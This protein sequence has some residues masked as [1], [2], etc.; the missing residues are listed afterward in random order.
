[1]STTLHGQ[2]I[3]ANIKYPESGF[4]LV[5]VW[6]GGR[7]FRNTI[8]SSPL[9]QYSFHITM[10]RSLTRVARP[11]AVALARSS[12]LVCVADLMIHQSILSQAGRRACSRL[13]PL[14]K[15]QSTFCLITTMDR[16]QDHTFIARKGSLVLPTRMELGEL[17]I[18]MMGSLFEYL[19]S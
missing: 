11:T 12:P 7:T 19:D 15:I 18:R 10:L 16:W 14:S 2:E 4:A 1:M 5:L 13:F 17:M 8:S 3:H 6:I 9:S